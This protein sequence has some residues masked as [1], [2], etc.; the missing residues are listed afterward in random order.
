V[1]RDRDLIFI[2][3]LVPEKGADL[4]LAAVA[5]LACEGLKMRTTIVGD[6]P[7][8]PALEATACQMALSDCV[9]FTGTLQ[10]DAL[11]R[12]LNRHEILVIPSRWNEPFGIVA[13]EGIAS[14]CVA[15]G[16]SGGGLSEA[17]GGCGLVFQSGDV[18][19]LAGALRKLIESDSCRR[20]LRDN[21]A[22]HLE[23]HKP[24]VVAERYLAAALVEGQPLR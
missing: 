20:R 18:R 3:R 7:M 22:P 19:A 21:A 15:V 2:G 13:L 5:S 12:I 6:G 11:R 10:G 24:A 16:S 4:L 17:I 23:A 14:G 1:V 9:H 8:R